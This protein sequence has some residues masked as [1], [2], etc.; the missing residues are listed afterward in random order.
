VILIGL[1]GG[2]GAGKSSVSSLLASRGAVIIDADAIVHQLQR[3]GEPV[4]ASIAAR[5]GAHLIGPD[6]ELDR[7][8]LAAVVFGD[9]AA[10][11]DLNGIVHPAV[12]VEINRRIDAEVDAD[13]VVVL[14]IPLLAENP[15]PGLAATVVVDCPVEVAVARLTHQ[16]GFTESDARARIARQ[17][18]REQRLA[19][20]TRVIDNSGDRATLERQVDEL[21]AWLVALPPTTADDLAAYRAW[22][23]PATSPTSATSATS[24]SAATNEHRVT[25]S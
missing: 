7:A 21:W 3:P 13:H 5:F 2:I 4:V 25:K 9:A 15:R 12:G 17:V 22:P 20:A 11:K 18:S 16:R 14:D 23:A 10:L 19:L 8:A 1:T 6:G 24:G